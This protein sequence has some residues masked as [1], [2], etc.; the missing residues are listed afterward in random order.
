MKSIYF[1]LFS[2]FIGMKMIFKDKTLFLS[3]VIPILINILLYVGLA[4][5]LYNYYGDILSLVV[6]TPDT[7][8]KK[9]LYWISFVFFLLFALM[10]FVL[11]FNIVGSMLLSP[12]NTIIA[13]A[14][15]K[16]LTGLS[17][18]GTSGTVLKDA[19][20][21]F[22]LDLKKLIL[23]FIPLGILYVISFFIPVLSI[24]ALVLSFL[25]ITYQYM[26]YIMEEKA[27]KTS[28]R[29]KILLNNPLK[30]TIFGFV[31][32]IAVSIPVIGL[33]ILPSSVVGAT[34][35]FYHLDT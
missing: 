19:Y 3:S 28:Q 13:K 14:S 20:K 34:V 21:S 29:V 10:V 11:S 15:Y 12:F 6:K 2:P 22:K 18:A 5:L 32:S 8:F 24:I 27:M 26:D 16:S 1:A 35:L 31:V 9:L 30:S 33:I 17:F 7:F 23:I 4:L 25:A